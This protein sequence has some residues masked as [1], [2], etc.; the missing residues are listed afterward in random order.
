MKQKKEKKSQAIK[1]RAKEQN[2]WIEYL[3][4]QLNEMYHNE[5]KTTKLN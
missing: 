4:Q 2:E 5:I 3:I 1:Q